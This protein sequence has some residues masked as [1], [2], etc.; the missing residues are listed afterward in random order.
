LILTEIDGSGNSHITHAFNTETA[1]QL[2]TWLDGFEA[3]LSQM[4]DINFDF[5]IHALFLLFTEL[6]EQRI[7]KKDWKLPNQ[8][9]QEED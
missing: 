4:T 3:Q 5:F 2:N 9:W 6:T 8:F 7:A 1:K